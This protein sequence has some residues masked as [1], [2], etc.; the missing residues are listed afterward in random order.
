M[1][2]VIID[3]RIKLSH[4]KEWNHAICD[5]MD[6]ARGYYAK[7]NKLGGESQI[8]YDFTYT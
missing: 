4:K 3:N 1:K 6:V 8:L 7:W 2:M 5:S